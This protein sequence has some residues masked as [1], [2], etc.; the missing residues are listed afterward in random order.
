MARRRHHRRHRRGFGSMVSIPSLGALNPK[1]ILGR[2]NPLNKSV[3]STDVLIGAAAGMVGSGLVKKGLDAVWKNQPAFISNN[4]DVIGSVL[5]GVGASV[6]LGKNNEAKANGIVL[7]A[8]IAGAVPTA[9]AWL[10][11]ALPG[12]SGITDLDMGGFLVSDAD[13]ALHGFL[14]ND[15]AAMHGLAEGPVMGAL[16]EHAMG[17]DE[18]DVLALRALVPAY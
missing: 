9:W 7:G 13:K 2:L 3:R 5:A 1:K 10:R 18:D 14:V 15:T 11:N 12:L 6:V 4:A 8:L 16:A 17:P